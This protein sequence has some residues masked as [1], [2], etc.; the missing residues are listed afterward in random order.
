LWSIVECFDEAGGGEDVGCAPEL[1]GGG[2]AV[3]DGSGK[4]DVDPGL[5][6]VVPDVVECGVHESG[7]VREEGGV[8]DA[9]GQFVELACLHHER[10]IGNDDVDVL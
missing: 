9:G 3:E 8:E 4:E 6:K 10:D 1:G 2:E 5:D 7:F